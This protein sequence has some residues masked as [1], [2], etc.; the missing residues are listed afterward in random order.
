MYNDE[1]IWQVINHGHC[2][3]KT[4]VSAKSTFCR[5][6]YNYNGLCNRSSCPLANSQYATVLEDK[7][8]AYLCMKTVERAHLPKQLWERIRLSRNYTK[9][10]KQLDKHLEF[11][12][13]LMIHRNKQR[14]TKIH[15]FL[16]RVRRIDAN[17]VEATRAIR[18]KNGLKRALVS[19]EAKALKA[20]DLGTSIEKELLARLKSGTYGDIYNF[21]EAQYEKALD[22]AEKEFEYEDEEEAAEP[23]EYVAG[24]EDSD[25][26]EADSDDDD[27]DDD[28]SDDDSEGDGPMG[29]GD[30]LEDIGQA[31]A[32]GGLG[33]DDDEDSEDDDD[34]DDDDDASG[35]AAAAAASAAAPA[36]GRSAKRARSTDGVEMPGKRG[37]GAAGD[38]RP[39][40]AAAA[41]A[42]K[43]K[44][45][46]KARGPR[47]EV[48]YEG[49]SGARET[50]SERAVTDW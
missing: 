39:A 8:R 28:D 3:Y 5:N 21:P 30:D 48:E 40:A 25:D 24:E 43:R 31:F 12:P 7:G 33:D 2:A 11:W 20:A 15:Q 45:R 44:P 16:L 29:F 1:L 38:A 41:A 32:A 23:S 13:K 35:P 19:R 26:E 37:R 18:E 47:V 6:K 9:A 4:K 46:R 17:P 36:P 14:L 10:L 50:A 22:K 27:D 34:D 42:G 49:E